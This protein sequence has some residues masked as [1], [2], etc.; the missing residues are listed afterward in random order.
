VRQEA[1]AARRGLVGSGEDL[2]LRSV[3]E[4]IA[5]VVSKNA[6]CSAERHE[7]SIL[8]QSVDGRVRDEARLV[9]PRWQ[10]IAATAPLMRIFRPPSF[11]VSSRSVR[12]HRE[13]RRWRPWCPRAGPD[14]DDRVR[15][16]PSEGRSEAARSYFRRSGSVHERREM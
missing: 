1:V 8:R 4:W 14:D 9:D 3:D 13:P 5:E 6:R 2:G 16:V 10:N 15:R 12:R 11:V 7:R